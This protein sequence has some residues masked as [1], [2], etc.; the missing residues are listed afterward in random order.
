MGLDQ[1]AFILFSALKKANI[2]RGKILTLG[3]Q[4]LLFSSN[5]LSGMKLDGA[6]MPKFNVGEFADSYLSWLGFSEVS[7]LDKSNFEGA[8]MLADLCV[9]IAEEMKGRFDFVFDGGTSEHLIDPIQSFENA[10]SL[11]SSSGISAWI[12][13]ANNQMGHGLWQISPQA[14]YRIVGDYL[15]YKNVEV[16]IVEVLRHRKIKMWFVEDPS[17]VANRGDSRNAYS[18]QVICI[19]KKGGG[20][21]ASIDEI[22]QSDYKKAWE[23]GAH[24]K[25]EQGCGVSIRIILSKILRFL[26]LG[27]IGCISPSRFKRPNYIPITEKEF[28]HRIKMWSSR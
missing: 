17:R 28:E 23:S 3:R 21:I 15:G 18:V 2:T 12:L 26:N 25:S 24:E 9:P 6:K 19:G 7:S 27:W 10:C 11:T 5:E 1:A 22:A 13:P 4:N 14:F 20:S 8:T 16:Y